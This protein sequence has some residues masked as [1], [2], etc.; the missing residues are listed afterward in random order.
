VNN[1]FATA[2]IAF[3]ALSGCQSAGQSN[4][5][6]PSPSQ[7]VAAGEMADFCRSQASQQLGPALENMSTDY[8]VRTASGTRVRGTWNSTVT[9]E[10]AGTFQCNFGPNGQFQSVRQI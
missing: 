5:P 2:A 10:V 4:I 9:G 8:P 3:L 6:S 7:R 1:Q